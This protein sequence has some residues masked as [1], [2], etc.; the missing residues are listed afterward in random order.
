M[1][2]CS[3]LVSKKIISET[4]VEYGDSV[5]KEHIKAGG[6]QNEFNELK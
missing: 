5:L 2:L 1:V 3:L 6:F 4:D